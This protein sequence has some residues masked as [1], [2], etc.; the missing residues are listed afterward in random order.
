MFCSFW[1]QSV[2]H[3]P[4]IIFTTCSKN[5]QTPETHA[6]HWLGGEHIYKSATRRENHI[7]INIRYF[8][9]YFSGWQFQ[10]IFL[11][12]ASWFNNTMEIKHM[13]KREDWD[14]L[15]RESYRWKQKTNR[16]QMKS[17]LWQIFRAARDIK[18]ISVMKYPISTNSV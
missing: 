17:F 18:Q 6:S 12:N 9:F 15:K 2:T 8:I 13:R 5:T 3:V 14:G 11:S 16:K 7:L 4:G 10:I 1:K